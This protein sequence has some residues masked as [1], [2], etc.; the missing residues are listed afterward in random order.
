MPSALSTSIKN[1]FQNLKGKLNLIYEKGEASVITSMVLEAVC[2]LKY[3][4]LLLHPEKHFSILEEQ[5]WQ[6]YAVELL[7]NRPVQ[8]VLGET[9]FYGLTL[10]VNETVL[11]PRPETEELVDWVVKET[12][13][14]IHP[15]KALKLLDMG[16]GSGCIA[17]ALKKN[18]HPIEMLAVDSSEAALETAKENAQRN[19]LEV[20]FLQWNMLESKVPET[21]KGIDILIS[22]PPYITLEERNKMTA[23]VLN[24]EPDLAL[25]VTNKDP[26]QF[27]KRIEELGRTV[28][29]I[30]GKIYL[31]LNENYA[32]AVQNYFLQKGWKSTIRRDFQG[33]ERMLSASGFSKS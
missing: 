21:L 1:A 10:K 24:F 27:Y 7:N 14:E 20:S 9:L 4:D 18:L 17:L 30:S 19:H 5:K 25:F 8:Y 33:K 23:N 6:Q 29:K 11:I 13:Q 3:S 26:L 22:N 12:K 2:G 16:T 15:E 32:E 28:L 31:E